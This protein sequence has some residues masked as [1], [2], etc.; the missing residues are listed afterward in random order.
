[1]APLVTPRLAGLDP[2]AEAGEYS[3]HFAASRAMFDCA[4]RVLAG[5][6]THDGWMVEP[7]PVYVKEARGA[8]KWDADGHRLIDFWMGHGALIK[9]HAFPPVTAAVAGQAARGSHY[10]AASE[11][12]VLWAE[13]V[14]SLIPSA[15]RVRFTSSGTEATM[16]ALRV[17]RAY[18]GRNLIIKLDGH[19]HG[20]HDE[21]LAQF[22][23]AETA[24][25]NRGT[26]TG[27]ATASPFAAESVI[28]LL[29]EEETAAV[30]LEPGGGGGGS[31]PWDWQFLAKLREATHAHGALLIFDE[32]ISAFRYSPGGVQG[33]CG[34]FPDLTVLAKILSGG[35]P[36]GAVAGRAEFMDVF[37]AGKV[38]GGRRA[39]VPHTGTFNGNPLSAAAGIAL[40]SH[41][42]DGTAQAQADAAARLMV[43]SVNQIANK[44]RVD[45]HLY[46]Q[47]SI[48]HILIGARQAGVSLEPSGSVIALYSQYPERYA[49]LRRALLQEGVDTHPVH[50]WMSSAHDDGVIARAV[51]AFDRAMRRLRHDPGFAL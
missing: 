11:L 19:F 4:R 26:A 30:I 33:L 13:L 41:V 34:I 7:F 12:E 51:E 39:K 9:G 27:V 3:D 21:A 31:L 25:I 23:P 42:G 35:L 28:E 29:D 16:L 48:F 5:G 17:A 32:V 18:T 8:H 37:G 14:C 20:W 10:G 22:V 2:T 6:T 44:L 43:D 47:S 49:A 36:G 24:G 40:L 45:V 46:Q 1:M 50:G 15:E 38:V